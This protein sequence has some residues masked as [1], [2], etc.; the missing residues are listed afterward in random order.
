MSAHMKFVPLTAALMFAFAA[1]TQAQSQHAHHDDARVPSDAHTAHAHGAHGSHHGY[2]QPAAKPSAHADHAGMDHSA[3]AGMDHSGMDHAAAGHAAP[4][5]A[6]MQHGTAPAPDARPPADH[7]PPPPP[8]LDIGHLTHAQMDA[9]M[10]MNDNARFGRFMLDRLEY[11][12]G[13]ATA[14]SAQAWYG[15]DSNRVHFRSEGQR[16]DGTLE[17]ADAELLWSHAI[18]PFWDSQLG[19]RRDF[20]E[21]PGRTWAAFGVQGLAP[22]WFELAATAYV[23]EQ[24]RTALRVEADYELLL[25]Q[26]LVLQPRFELNA[27]GKDDPARRIGSGL[28]DAEAGLRLR[29][30][31]RREFAPYVGVEW[32][33]GFGRTADFARAD[34]HDVT[35]VRWVAGVRVWF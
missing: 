16:K 4:A 17:H 8:T 19:I 21:G 14:W 5:H 3:H 2:G 35:D 26:R 23:G 7:V 29:Y 18:A 22:Y 28:S 25:T 6:D 15:G 10:G 20:G 9:V 31:I 1:S 13:G 27:Y 24:G 12:E 34:G 30:E 11:V 32:S 33:S